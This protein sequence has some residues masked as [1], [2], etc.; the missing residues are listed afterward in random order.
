MQAGLDFQV[1]LQHYI[2]HAP[3]GPLRDEFERVFHDIQLGDS[4]TQALRALHA[5]TT[6]PSLQE[7]ARTVLQGLELGAPLTPLLREQARALR[8]YHAV[9]AEKK[10]A[11]APLKLLFP[12]LVFIFPTIFIVLL[13]PLL[14]TLKHGGGS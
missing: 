12:L 2:R 8:Q 1:A 14:V 6:D 11:V 13:G 3:A 9:Q 5:R 7:T 10:A 4:R